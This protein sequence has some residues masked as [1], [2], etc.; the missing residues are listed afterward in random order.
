M[1]SPLTRSIL[2]TQERR[3]PGARA[4]ITV[5]YVLA[6]FGLSLVYVAKSGMVD[7]GKKS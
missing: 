7:G 4:V 5:C 2:S 6:L 1:S 3:S